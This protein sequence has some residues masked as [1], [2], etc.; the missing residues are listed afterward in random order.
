S[1]AFACGPSQESQ[2]MQVVMC[3][4]LGGPE[5]L[6][7]KSVASPSPGP[8]EVK[9]RLRARGASYTDVLRVAGQY[10]IKS[11]AP[12]SPG[13]G[14][15]GEIIELGA[16]VEGLS[17]GDRVLCAGGFAEEAVEAARG[18]VKLPE[19]VG[20][21]AAAAFRSNYTT[22]YYALQRARLRAGETLLVHGG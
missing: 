1:A 16:D 6:V 3:E 15:A 17:I 20:F 21:E 11:E 10:Q 22:A 14:A 7:V 13:G 9:I 2:D 8:A 4:V 12:F 18:L 19:S 5:R